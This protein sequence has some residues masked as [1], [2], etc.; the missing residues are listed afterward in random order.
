MTKKLE[1]LEKQMEQLK[2]RMNLEKNRIKTK[3]RKR[4]TRRKILVGAYFMEQYKDRMDELAKLIDP[5][6]TRE[7]D[8]ELFDLN[9]ADHN[10]SQKNSS[11]VKK[12]V[13]VA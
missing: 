3:E 2:A 12:N 9:Q 1:Q 8:R 10:T 13:R 4:D 5:F 6:L 11:E 7:N